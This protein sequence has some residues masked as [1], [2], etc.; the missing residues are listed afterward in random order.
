MKLIILGSG[1]AHASE[2][3]INDWGDYMGDGVNIGG[4]IVMEYAQRL[5]APTCLTQG[6]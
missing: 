4:A 2:S 6:W 5:D 1:Q 3:P